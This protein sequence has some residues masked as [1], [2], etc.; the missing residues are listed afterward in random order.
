M[1][2]VSGNTSHAILQSKLQTCIDKLTRPIDLWEVALYEM[3]YLDT[4]DYK[5][6]F[7]YQSEEQAK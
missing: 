1:T 6:T 4:H 5:G 7:F 3:C 2:S